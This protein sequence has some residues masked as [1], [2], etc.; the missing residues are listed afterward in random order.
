MDIYENYK[1]SLDIT[2]K[3]NNIET[4]VFDILKKE[5]DKMQAIVAKEKCQSKSDDTL[6]AHLVDIFTAIQPEN[7]QGAWVT[8]WQ[9]LGDQ[10]FEANK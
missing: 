9:E 2:T 5:F 8:R 7:L 1:K 10:Y 6:R 3:L 4:P